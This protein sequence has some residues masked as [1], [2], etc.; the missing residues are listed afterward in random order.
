[1]IE[2]AIQKQIFNTPFD[3][4]QLDQLMG[5]TDV[6]RVRELLKKEDMDRAEYAELV[7][8]LSSNE[9]KTQNYDQWT[10]YVLSKFNVWINRFWLIL[11]GIYDYEKDIEKAGRDNISR[12]TDK[13]FKQTI[14]IYQYILK[15]CCNNYFNIARSSLSVAAIGFKEPMHN[16]HDITYSMPSM[17]KPEDMKRS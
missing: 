1:M 17:T 14:R 9:I 4:S 6:E 3:R 13:S 2:E 11:E 10:R 16:V 12:T 8:F 15:L 5:K 7:S